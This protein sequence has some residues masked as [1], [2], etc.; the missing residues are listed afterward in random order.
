MCLFCFV[1]VNR[2]SSHSRTTGRIRRNKRVCLHGQKRPTKSSRKTLSLH[3]NNGGR[4]RC[5]Q[6]SAK[7]S[8]L[9]RQTT[10]RQE[11]HSERQPKVLF[12]HTGRG[13]PHT[14]ANR[15]AY[16]HQRVQKHAESQRHPAAFV[17]VHK[18]HA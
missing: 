18:Q 10:K 5:S 13:R 3:G 12:G 6:N 17:L 11:R 2:R 15:Q 9:S 7:R 14:P 8:T 16:A 4:Q 1:F